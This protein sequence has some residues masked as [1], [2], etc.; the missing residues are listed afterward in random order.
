MAP[1]CL[2]GEWEEPPAAEA[3]GGGGGEGHHAREPEQS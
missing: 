2:T 1:C 3:G